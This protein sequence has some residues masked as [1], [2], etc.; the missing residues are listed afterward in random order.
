M[1]HVMAGVSTAFM[2]SGQETHGAGS[3]DLAAFAATSPAIAKLRQAIIEGSRARHRRGS[4]G[5]SMSP[6]NRSPSTPLQVRTRIGPRSVQ[7]DHDLVRSWLG[8]HAELPVH[9]P[10]VIDAVTSSPCSPE[11]HLV[12]AVEENFCGSPPTDAQPRP[13]N[14]PAAV[15]QCETSPA[16]GS[17]VGSAGPWIPVAR[18]RG[19]GPLPFD[20]CSRD[21]Q[22]TRRQPRAATTDRHQYHPD[23][24]ISP[25]PALSQPRSRL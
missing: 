4:C 7:S 11:R 2:R 22:P 14:R 12:G 23:S 21:V 3:L 24:C 13:R 10:M 18:I 20:R 19:I 9:R 8:N 5:R 16:T 1:R 6:V 15:E 25:P 17:E